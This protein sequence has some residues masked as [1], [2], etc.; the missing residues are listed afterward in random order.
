MGRSQAVRHRVLVPTY[1][2]SNP[3][4]PAI[5]ISLKINKIL[6]YG[7]IKMYTINYFIF[8]LF[9]SRIFYSVDSFKEGILGSLR[10][11]EDYTSD[12][13]KKFISG[14][15]DFRKERFMKLFCA[16]IDKERELKQLKSGLYS[17]P[18]NI[19][20]TK[21]ELDEI[22]ENMFAIFL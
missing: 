6:N 4:A 14:I 8:F 22:L 2:G 18:K 16:Y 5:F 7:D 9:C 19:E 3:S 10:I 11:I 15:V 1:G 13:K 12:D 20:K 21:K 17:D